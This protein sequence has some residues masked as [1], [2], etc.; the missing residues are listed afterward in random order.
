VGSKKEAM[1]D[2]APMKMVERK[3]RGMEKS[4]DRR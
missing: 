2:R 4:R 1:S 3:I